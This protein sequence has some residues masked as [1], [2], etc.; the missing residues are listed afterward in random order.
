MSRSLLPVVLSVLLLSGCF[1]K[2][3]QQNHGRLLDGMSVSDVRQILGEPTESDS[4]D[5]GFIRGTRSVWREDGTTITVT[6]MQDK[7]QTKSF[8]KQQV[9]KP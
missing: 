1:S 7:L 4:I 2:V 9:K 6:F 8:N 5:L 3:N